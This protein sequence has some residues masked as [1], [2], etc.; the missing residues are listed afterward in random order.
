[1]RRRTRPLAADEPFFEQLIESAPDAMLV[2]DDRGLVAFANRRCEALTGWPREELL[3]RSVEVLVPEGARSAHPQRRLGYAADPT[4]RPMGAGL[5]LHLLA[6]DGRE[7]PVDISLSPFLHDGRRLVAAAIRDV[8]DRQRTEQDLRRAQADLERTVGELRRSTDLLVMANELGDLLHSCRSVDDAYLVLTRYGAAFFPGSSGAVYRS[9]ASGTYLELARTWG[10]PAPFD[11]TFTADGC[12]AFRRGRLHVRRAAEDLP[13]AHLS[14]RCRSACAPLL[15]QG[16]ILGILVVCIGPGADVP[17]D[18]EERARSLGEHLSLALANILLRE[19]LRAQSIR[20]PLTGLYNRRYLDEHLHREF[21]RSA[22]SG[23]PI[24][25][26]AVDLDHF[27]AYNDT[28]G[29]AAGDSALI[30][31]ASMLR[32][33]SRDEDF[34]CRQ[35]GEEFLVVL[36]GATA[37]QAEQRAEELRRAC[38]DLPFGTGRSLTMSIGVASFPEHGGTVDAVLAA[39]DAALYAAKRGGRDRVARASSPV[40]GDVDGPDDSGPRALPLAERRG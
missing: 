7:V 2:V 38:A 14:E 8:T 37:D 23:A 40:E 35:G 4:A 25:L 9:G 11:A 33:R 28:Y 16:E 30:S 34:V 6:I 36:P 18:L 5:D 32:L 27:K 39:V 10:D 15:A 31:I 24:G 29:H 1:V 20:D 12:W 26:L 3:G 17:D 21:H 19:T 22:R 13:C